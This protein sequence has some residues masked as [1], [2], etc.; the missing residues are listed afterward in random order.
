MSPVTAIRLIFFMD[1][2]IIAKWLP[3]L[4]DIQAHLGL[5]VGQL[6]LALAALPLGIMSSLPLVGTFVISRFSERAA[7]RVTFL[8]LALTSTLPGLAWDFPS[9]AIALFFY[10]SGIAGVEVAMNA[11]ADAVESRVGRRIMSSCHGLWSVGN[12]TG[13]ALG[14]LALSLHLDAIVTFIVAAPILM[15][16]AYAST[17][18]LGHS[19]ISSEPG[20]ALA[21]PDFPLLVLCLLPFC[22]CVLEGAMADWAAVY[23]RIEHGAQAALTGA[24]FGVFAAVMAATRLTGDRLVDRVGPVFIAHCCGVS[25]VL[26]LLVIWV[27]PGVWPALAGFALMGFAASLIFPISVTAAARQPGRS[28][29]MN[30]ASLSLICFS[31]YVIGPPVVGLIADLVGLR[32]ALAC[33]IPFALGVL[34]LAPRLQPRAAVTG[35]A[36]AQGSTHLDHWRASSS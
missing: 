14:S 18:R 29:A 5:D 26:G 28:A 20:P 35:T 21:L 33:L 8:W 24:G 7:I 15:A 16:L 22:A 6:G 1:G 25:G 23:L 27:A 30:I 36:T 31:G 9:F 12:L 11:T 34:L 3:H 2:L 32:N 4:P 19:P 13:A 17:G 10:G